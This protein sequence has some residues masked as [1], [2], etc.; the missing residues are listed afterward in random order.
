MSVTIAPPLIRLR[1]LVAFLGERKQLGWWDCGF[2]D[3]TGRSYL[4]H[5][6]PR[7]AFHAALRS[8]TAAAAAIHD[9]AIGRNGA[10]HLFR[11]PV[12]REEALDI[13]LS[14]VAPGPLLPL[15]ASREAALSALADI[16]SVS[17]PAAAGPVQIGLEKQLGSASIAGSIA[18][19]YHAAFTGGD[20]PSFP[21]FAKEKHA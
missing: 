7:T 9:R 15:I 8:T 10:Y 20:K 5:P 14:E 3:N 11:L 13:K 21:Y 2:L 12:E 4:E 18:A 16:S 17:V 6:F 1:L 19:H